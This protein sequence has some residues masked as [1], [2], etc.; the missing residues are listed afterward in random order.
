MKVIAGEESFGSGIPLQIA[1]DVIV[2]SRRDRRYKFCKK[3]GKRYIMTKA[4]SLK[5]LA[6]VIWFAT[7]K[8]K[9]L[10]I[11]LKED[12]NIVTCVYHQRIFEN[13]IDKGISVEKYVS[14]LKD[15]YITAGS[16]IFYSNA[17]I[18]I[19]DREITYSIIDDRLVKKLSKVSVPPAQLAAIVVMAVIAFFMVTVAYKELVN[20][21]KPVRVHKKTE[22]YEEAYNAFL[23]DQLNA[24]LNRI[25]QFL[26]MELDAAER[27]FAINKDNVTVESL[28]YK[29]SYNQEGDI[30]R[31]TYGI[32]ELSMNGSLNLGRY[33]PEVGRCPKEISDAFKVVGY[34]VE[35][36]RQDMP[37]QY[38]EA[39]LEARSV[40]YDEICRILKTSLSQCVAVKEIKYSKEGGFAIEASK[41]SQY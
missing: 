38:R 14:K 2:K 34:K 17:G 19:P 16:F 20:S 36:I 13:Y 41:Y 40:N 26:S 9:P 31:K 27:V 4:L 23:K 15:I 12:D 5:Y 22:T 18:R 39:V 7:D 1:S 24:S 25:K 29:P 3:T 10:V 8:T 21:K 37:Y 33:V 28:V 30:Y 35:K 6:S 11:S 32:S